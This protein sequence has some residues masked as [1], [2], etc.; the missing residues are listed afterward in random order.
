MNSRAICMP[1]NQHFPAWRSSQGEFLARGLRH[2]CLVVEKDRRQRG[3]NNTSFRK[4]KVNHVELGTN[5][6]GDCDHRSRI[7]FRR[8][9]R[10]GELDRTG[11]VLRISRAVYH[12]LDSAARTTTRRVMRHKPMNRESS[13]DLFLP[14]FFCAVRRL[15]RA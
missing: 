14:S 2:L 12:Q 6:S 11:F 1:T 15:I 9:R 4:G 8:H 13:A 5:I 10:H 7:W 3:I